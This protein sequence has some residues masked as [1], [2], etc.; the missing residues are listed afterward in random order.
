MFSMPPK[1]S[2]AIAR[3]F[4]EINPRTK[5]RIRAGQDDGVHIGVVV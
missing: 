5:R 2:F 3:R 4:F 1:I